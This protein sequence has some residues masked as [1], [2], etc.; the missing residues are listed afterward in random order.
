[1][2]VRGKR[3]EGDKGDKGEETPLTALLPKHD[4]AANIMTSP[5]P[6]SLWTMQRM[7]R[8]GRRR[9]PRCWRRAAWTPCMY[10]ES[11][12]GMRV[13]CTATPLSDL[14]YWALLRPSYSI[15]ARCLA[16]VWL[17]SPSSCLCSHFVF[18]SCRIPR[19][20]LLLEPVPSQVRAHTHTHTPQKHTHAHTRTTGSRTRTQPSLL[21]FTVHFPSQCTF[22]RFVLSGGHVAPVYVES[23]KRG[24]KVC[25]CACVR[26]CAPHGSG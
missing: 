6:F 19:P 3:R 7:W 25:V 14:M 26:A 20:R 12:D 5:P 15:P 11:I 4:T 24:I 2:R 18:L 1:M 10:G 9:W 22:A 17:S 21:S 13:L 8:M 23:A 16:Y